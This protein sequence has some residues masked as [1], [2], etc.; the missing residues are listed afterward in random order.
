MSS[1][2]VRVFPRRQRPAAGRH[3]GDEHPF[4]GSSTVPMESLCRQRPDRPGTGHRPGEHQATWSPVLRA[5]GVWHERVCPVMI[6][7]TGNFEESS[8]GTGA[9]D[10]AAGPRISRTTR[11][12][13][14]MSLGQPGALPGWKG[15]GRALRDQAA[16][17]RSQWRR[18]LGLV[19]VA[20][21]VL[22]I[23]SR[24]IGL[25]PGHGK[26]RGL[27]KLTLHVLPELE[28]AAGHLG[29]IPDVLA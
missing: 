22:G 12:A 16:P 3:R 15:G 28:I 4:I 1:A 23:L 2:A 17:E 11:Q 8:H 19:R 25:V 27:E 24:R 9:G 20:R 13:E 26:A 29:H 18:T 6:V 21:F 10:S 5:N 14:I 7:S